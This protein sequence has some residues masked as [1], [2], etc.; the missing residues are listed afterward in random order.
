MPAS[1]PG[2]GIAFADQNL[3]DRPGVEH[4]LAERATVAVD[5]VADQLDPVGFGDQPLKAPG[6]ELGEPG[7]GVTVCA[8][9]ALGG[10]DRGDADPLGAI[11]EGVAIDHAP[12]F[13]DCK[14]R[15]DRA[16]R[17]RQRDRRDRPGRAS[18]LKDWRAIGHERCA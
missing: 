16:N 10:I 18:R 3:T 5:P 1:F 4:D 15:S 6:G 13:L 9:V 2:H 8:P 14:G 11:G 7:L 17:N 12:A